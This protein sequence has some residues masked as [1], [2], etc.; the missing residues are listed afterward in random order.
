LIVEGIL[1]TVGADGEVHLSAMGAAVE[2]SQARAIRQM[3][4]RPYQG[5]RTLNNLQRSG[6]AVFHV[7]DDVELLARAAVRHIETLPKLLPA[8][9]VRG[10]I[11]ADACRWYALR[12]TRIDVSGPRA[13]VETQVVEEGR[14]RDFLGLNRAKHAVVEA[15]IVASRAAILPPGEVRDAFARLAAL[16]E[17]TGGE[18]E[19]R[20][21]ALLRE[22]A[23]SPQRRDC[24]LGEER[25]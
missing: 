15:A 20:A 5:T 21:F 22:L 8:S 7:T 10:W 4:L 16:V 19:R 25:P 9:A 13:A 11:L 1:T 14:I 3:E 23:C 24:P 18:A 17:K 6:E 2:E 12:V